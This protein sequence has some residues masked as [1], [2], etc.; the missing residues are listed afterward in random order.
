MEKKAKLLLFA[1]VLIILYTEI[2]GANISFS[3]NYVPIII[4]IISLVILN[5]R[6]KRSYAST[7]TIIAT[8]LIIIVLDF[9][10]NIACYFLFNSLY[11]VEIIRLSTMLPIAVL[12]YNADKIDF[13]SGNKDYFI[14]IA[15]YF[16][17]PLLLAFTLEQSYIF[18]V[19]CIAQI[20]SNDTLDDILRIVFRVIAMDI[21]IVLLTLSLNNEGNSTFNSDIV[22]R[23]IFIAIVLIMVIVLFMKL[24]MIIS[25][26]ISMNSEISKLDDIYPTS[27]IVDYNSLG[28]YVDPTE[29]ANSSDNESDD[30]E[31]LPYM[32]NGFNEFYTANAY[33]SLYKYRL[34]ISEINSLL[35]SGRCTIN[36]ALNSYNT[37]TKNEIDLWAENKSNLIFQIISIMIIYIA[38]FVS[39]FVVYKAK[40]SI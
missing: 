36:Q 7:N 26:I 1:S 35:Q 21:T 16:I 23:N 3:L 29:V 20:F 18:F 33:N 34:N 37:Y 15:K 25:C 5:I 14:G 32:Q 9:V 13:T 28:L 38:N 27:N 11:E 22:T 30:E 19:S 2:V 24:S 8:N 39:V 40:E 12:A 31:N 6:L 17:L 4:L 10:V